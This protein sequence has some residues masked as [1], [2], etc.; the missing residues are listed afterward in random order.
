MVKTW[1]DENVKSIRKPGGF[2]GKRFIVLHAENRGGFV[3]NA[4]LIFSTRSKLD[5]Y[6][7]DMNADL[8]TK[9]VKDQLIPNL[10]QP[11]LIVM[12]NA[13]YHSVQV[14]K[15]QCSA[16]K[17]VDVV[18]WLSTKNI[19]FDKKMLKAELLSLVKLY[20]KPTEY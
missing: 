1:R 7:G 4:N 17:M 14:E 8:F 10:E 20:T 9:W 2:D 5:D 13:P 18:K 6:H 3:K 19:P 15:Q 12:D 16:L 11:S